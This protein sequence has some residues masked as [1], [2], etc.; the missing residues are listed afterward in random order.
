MNLTLNLLLCAAVLACGCAA[1]EKS[2]PEITLKVA[3]EKPLDPEAAPLHAAA[4]VKGKP[5]D[6]VKLRG[7]KVA[8]IEFWAT[9]CPPCRESIPHLSALQKKY[10]D[11]VVFI[12]VTD[13]PLETVKPFVEKMGDG[14]A[15]TIMVD[16]Q[17]K[18]SAAYMAAFKEEYI[19]HAFIV[20]KSGKI[21]FHAH[22]MEDTFEP[23]LEKAVAAK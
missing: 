10:A 13:E 17:D 1:D 18:T 15:Y 11:K 5:V 12:G 4:W 14:I 9:W 20:D 7:K 23:A 6:L 3:A 21:V 8:V 16:D 2:K 22:P 19:P